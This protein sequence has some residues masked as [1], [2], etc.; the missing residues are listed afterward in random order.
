MR[1]TSS[2]VMTKSQRKKLMILLLNQTVVI[3]QMAP[4]TVPLKQQ[5]TLKIRK[6]LP[7]QQTTLKIRRIPLMINQEPLKIKRT[8]TKMNNSLN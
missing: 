8:A 1:Q 7:T 5:T 6:T 2:N 4:I 3:I